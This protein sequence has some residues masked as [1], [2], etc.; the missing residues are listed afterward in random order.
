MLFI[1]LVVL[2]GRFF[3]LQV[4]KAEEFQQ[5]AVDQRVLQIKQQPERGKIYDREGNPMVMSVTTYDIGIFPKFVKT[6]E[7]QEKM[8]NIIMKH[9]DLKESEVSKKVKSGVEWDNLAKRVDPEKAENLV[10]ELKENNLGYVQ[11]T[12]SPKRLYLNGDVGSS[13]LGFVNQE[14]QP[15]AGVEIAMNKYLG[16]VPGYLLAETYSRGKVIP[17]GFS[18]NSTPIKGQDVKLTIDTTMQKILEDRL[19]Q[20]MEE[21]H[22]KTVHGVLMNPKNGDIYAMASLPSFDPNDFSKSDSKNWTRNPA[23]Y[24]FEPGSTFKPLYMMQGLENGTINGNTR[25]QDN[26]G[27]ISVNGTWIKNWNRQPLGNA[28]LEDIILNSSNVGMIQISQTLKDEQVLAG[29]KKAGIGQKTGIE[30]PGEEQGLIPSIE[31]LKKDPVQ[32]ATMAFGQGLSVTPIQ[33]VSSFSE[34]I[35]G[36]KNI[37]PTILKEVKD[38]FGN[39]LYEQKEQKQEQMYK[40]ENADLIRGYLKSNMEKGSGKAVQVEGVPAGGKTGSA[41]VVENGAYKQGAIIGTFMGFA[42][43]DDPEFALLIVVDQ[44]QGAEFGSTAAG[45]T[46]HDVMSEVMKYK[47]TEDAK[48]KTSKTIQVPS[49]KWMLYEDAKKKIEQEVKDVHVT[50]KGKGNVVVKNSYQY[51]NNTLQVEL[52]TK[53]VK[54]NKQFYIPNLVGKTKQEVEEVLQ[55]Q[56]LSIRFHGEGTVS[57]QSLQPGIHETIQDDAI[58]WMKK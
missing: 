29:L 2:M 11:L 7:Q 35:N 18:N 23:S 41:W 20:T 47:K 15:G 10:K 13:V 1:F 34:I 33:L 3:Y 22:P 54:E 28:S 4:I 50:K 32:H 52:E 17:V 43:F 9:L 44:P 42:P 6:K 14:N 46:W 51:K 58:F 40:K 49:V 57:E 19:K 26:A 31:S 36:G 12:H 53:E 5:K 24:V 38:E 30:M 8:T 45:P 48:D 25:F 27:G 37:T 56:G 39:T 55:K 16:G 21:L